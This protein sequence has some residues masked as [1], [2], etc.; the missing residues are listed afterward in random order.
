MPRTYTASADD[1]PP[2]RAN[3]KRPLAP[4]PPEHVAGTYTLQDGVLKGERLELRTG[5]PPR[6]GAPPTLLWHTPLGTW[7]HFSALWP[8]KGWQRIDDGIRW[9]R[10]T[11]TATG[12]H[13]DGPHVMHRTRTATPSWSTPTTVPDPHEGGTVNSNVPPVSFFATRSDGWTLFDG[14]E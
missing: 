3:G 13:I 8:R 12:L 1:G 5:P 2:P 11:T 10:V 6:P 14:I 7:E 9:W 4:P